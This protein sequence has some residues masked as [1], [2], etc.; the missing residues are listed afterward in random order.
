[1]DEPF[2]DASIDTA[3]NPSGLTGPGTNGCLWPP[4]QVAAKVAQTVALLHRLVPNIV[5]GD[6]EPITNAGSTPE[7][8]A[9]WMDAYPK[10]TGISLAFLHADV[11][12]QMSDAFEQILQVKDYAHARSIAFGIMYDGYGTLGAGSAVASSDSQWMQWA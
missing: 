8:Y 9:N 5:I 10:A 6:M 7:L 12:W 3:P 1:M 11:Q 2:W 4:D